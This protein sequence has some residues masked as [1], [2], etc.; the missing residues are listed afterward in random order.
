[1]FPHVPVLVSVL[2]AFVSPSNAFIF[3]RATAGNA[4]RA[5]VTIPLTTAG[6]QGYSA[7]VH[8]VRHALSARFALYPKTVN[9]FEIDVA[10]THTDRAIQATPKTS[11]FNWPARSRTP[12]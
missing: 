12:W 3:P 11:H 7:A 6:G 4:T 5:R 2:F 9:E 8:M 1:M 10:Y